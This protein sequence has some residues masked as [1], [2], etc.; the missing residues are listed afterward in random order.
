MNYI[1]DV[2][3]YGLIFKGDINYNDL[4]KIETECKERLD[5]LFEDREIKIDEIK[6]LSKNELIIKITLYKKQIQITRDSNP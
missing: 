4:P 1:P 5:S 6:R 3:T 2:D